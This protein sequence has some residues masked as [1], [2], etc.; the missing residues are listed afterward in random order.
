[1]K[2]GKMYKV[3]FTEEYNINGVQIPSG[4]NTQH[5]VQAKNKKLCSEFCGFYFDRPDSYQ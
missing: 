2:Q 3:N 1:M 5:V 4:K